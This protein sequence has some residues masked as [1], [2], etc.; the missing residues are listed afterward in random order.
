[1]TLHNDISQ[2]EV[3]NTNL[4][5]CLKMLMQQ[6]FA[7]RQNNKYSSVKWRA[8][9]SFSW[10]IPYWLSYH[11]LVF[12]MYVWVQEN[13]WAGI[14]FSVFLHKRQ[15]VLPIVLELTLFADNCNS[16]FHGQNSWRRGFRSAT[17]FEYNFSGL[18]MDWDRNLSSDSPFKKTNCKSD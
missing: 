5:L 12:F 8:S 17:W 6:S 3:S 13:V 15:N 18:I 1:M 16:S 11:L 14:P 9:H 7:V 2:S 10:S 4:L